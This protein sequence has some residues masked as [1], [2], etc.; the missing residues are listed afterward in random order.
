MG[1]RKPAFLLMSSTILLSSFP[2]CTTCVGS[3]DR[4]ESAQ[5]TAQRRSVS[6][7]SKEQVK[8]HTLEVNGIT[9][10]YVVQTPRDP[11]PG[12][13]APLIVLFPA[14]GQTPERFSDRKNI[15]AGAAKLGYLLAVPAANGS[16]K[17]E[18]CGSTPTVAGDAGTSD[19]KATTKAAVSTQTA[20]TSKVSAAVKTAK[21]A[22]GKNAGTDAADGSVPAG[23]KNEDLEFVR[24]MIEKVTSE[25]TADPQRIYL[26]G[27]GSGGAFA[28]WVAKEMPQR[29]SAV[30]SVASTAHCDR[31]AAD[32]PG[33][34][35]TVLII[36][37]HAEGAPAE[38]AAGG[39]PTLAYWLR[40]NRCPTSPSGTRADGERTCADGS[41]VRH[42]TVPNITDWPQKIG[43][44]YTMRYV[45]EFYGDT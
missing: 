16:F 9:R 25:Y 1:L 12:K 36:D 17:D 34:P 31:S 22:A 23:P 41:R 27:V 20:A 6:R 18:F 45:H 30:V 26:I 28:E 3:D 43:K 14:A 37:G 32:K 7:G 11:E 42:V 19:S 39:N 44:K 40:A 8:R 33:N 15:T 38:P 29:F 21:P 13:P 10:R 24:L 5:K 4:R 2:A 35:V